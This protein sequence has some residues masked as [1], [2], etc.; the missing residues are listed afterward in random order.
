[1]AASPLL[2]TTREA[3]TPTAVGRQVTARIEGGR[4][5]P[6]R[7]GALSTRAFI[8][9]SVNKPSIDVPFVLPGSP[10]S[11]SDLGYGTA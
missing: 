10:Q 3:G 9:P 7:L 6:R 1:M 2:S 5:L 11:Q 8:A 4:K